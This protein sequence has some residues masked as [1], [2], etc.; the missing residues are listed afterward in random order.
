MKS[1]SSRIVARPNR[2]W[3]GALPGRPPR[4]SPLEAP[5]CVI[6]RLQNDDGVTSVQPRSA[7]N[8]VHE[9]RS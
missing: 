9:S 4:S 8:Q 3:C 2:G 5:R 1:E 6:E 7:Y